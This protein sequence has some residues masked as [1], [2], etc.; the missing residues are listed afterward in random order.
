MPLEVRI[1]V[2]LRER[3]HVVTG[4]GMREASGVLEVLFVYV[5]V[6]SKLCAQ[7]GLALTTPRSGV[8]FSPDGTSQVP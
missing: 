4:R 1:V 7:V 6:L 5:G 8:A 2:T 3:E